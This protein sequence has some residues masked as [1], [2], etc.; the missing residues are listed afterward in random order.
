MDRLT[1]QERRRHESYARTA[2]AGIVNGRGETT[3]KAR[4]KVRKKWQAHCKSYGVSPYL[5]KCD[6]GTLARV[7]LNFC[8]KLRQGKRARKPVSAG[9]IGT[10]IGSVATQIALDRGTRPLQQSH[11]KTLILPI[12]HMLKG[13]GNFDPPTEKKLACHKY[14]ILFAVKNAYN[15]SKS[16]MREA[17]GNL[18]CIAFHYLLRIGE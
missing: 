18:I 14:L 12:Q 13:F 8:G 4:G 10:G 7:S 2:D 15:G 16:A 9:H 17:T 3:I 6:F 1:A 5:D 11:S